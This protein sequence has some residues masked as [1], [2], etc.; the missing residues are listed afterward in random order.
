MSTHENDAPRLKPP[1]VPPAARL[2]AGIRS[3]R[4][5]AH[6][7]ALCLR[8]ASDRS[9]W[10]DEHALLG[11]WDERTALLARLVPPNSSVIEFGAGRMVLPS[12]L[13]PGC[14]YTPSDIVKRSPDTIVIDL[15]SRELLSIPTHDVAVFSG[16]LEYIHDVPRLARHLARATPTVVTSYAARRASRFGLTWF[17]RRSSGWVN[18]YTAHELI[19]LFES[20]GFVCTKT[21]EWTPSRQWLFQFIRKDRLADR[22][23]DA[24]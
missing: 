17:R 11:A 9:R 14:T 6:T 21:S 1:T 8:N 3:L 24:R 16:V 10:Q 7:L 2:A 4:S 12:F 5:A 19:R 15:N 20:S 13:P 23:G 22:A 18:D